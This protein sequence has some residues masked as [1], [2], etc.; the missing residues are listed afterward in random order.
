MYEDLY[1]CGV[2]CNVEMIKCE[3]IEDFGLL[4]EKIYVIYNVIDNQ[5][6]LLL[7]EEI[8][9]VL[10]VKWQLLLQVICLI[11]VG[12]GFECKGLVVVI[13]VIVF[14]DC[15]LLVVGKDKDQLCY[16]VL[17]KSL[18]CEVWVCFFGMQLEILFFY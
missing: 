6:F 12:F 1:L 17:V 16:Q 5:C 15:Y 2:I 8:F 11:Y 14:I 10:C 9:V 4:V 3:I 18:N 13:C 7:D